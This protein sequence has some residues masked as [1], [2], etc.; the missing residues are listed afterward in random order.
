DE[1]AKDSLYVQ[2]EKLFKA[3]VD[4]SHQLGLKIILDVN[5]NH[6]SPAYRGQD[7]VAN[8]TEYDLQ[9]GAIFEDGKFIAAR[10]GYF[11]KIFGIKNT[12]ANWFHKYPSIVWDTKQRNSLREV[13]KK[14]GYDLVGDEPNAFEKENFMLHNLADLNQNN[15]NVFKYVLGA[16]SKWTRTGVDGFRIDAVRHIPQ[17]FFIKIKKRLTSINPKLFFIGEWFESG[18]NN[19]ESLKFASKSGALLFDFEKMKQIRDL[20]IKEDID[21]SGLK[22]ILERSGNFIN[23]IENQDIPRVLSVK[24][25][26]NELYEEMIKLLFVLEGVPSLYYG[27]EQYLHNDSYKNNRTSFGQIG[28]DPWNRDYMDWDI[29]GYKEK[30][31]YLMI[32]KL[33]KLR[34]DSNCLRDGATRLIP[35]DNSILAFERVLGNEKFLYLSSR[36][37]TSITTMT[38][39]PDGI[40][41]DK[42]TEV[43]YEIKGHQLQTQLMPFKAIIL[44]TN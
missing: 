20:Y 7:Y 22:K 31:I 29:S 21:Y 30:P 16:M 6:T 9:D 38:S 35:T 32:K 19:K 8:V 18:V 25:F 37:E 24:H 39:F 23:F 4:R 43:K 2:G 34:Q 41:Y 12:Q 44:S 15:K 27:T 17:D 13:Y 42:I 36:T 14:M 3:I 5:L 10:S 1:K 40:Y 33:A 28:G 26:D 11:E